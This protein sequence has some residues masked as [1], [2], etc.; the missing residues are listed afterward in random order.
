VDGEISG[1]RFYKGPQNL[2]T[3]IGNLWTATGTRLASATFT[4]ESAGGW[5]QVS[6]TNP[7]PVTAGTTYVASYFAPQGKY[8]VDENY[9]AA[10]YTNGPL[11]APSSASA[12][13]NGVYR[14]GSTSAFPN[15]TFAASNY[16]V[17]VVFRSWAGNQPPV[18]NPRSFPVAEDA[19]LTRAPTQLTVNDA[20]PAD[21][22]LTV[23][24]VA[25]ATNGT[26][27]LDGG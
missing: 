7:V 16:W 4:D 14:Y 15:A 27:H 25:G 21:D 11:T 12:G 23:T 17:D 18:A 13:G 10:T 1:I 3:H 26:V 5:Q 24:A 22:P 20:E 8:S 19:V 6:F 2:G 9:F